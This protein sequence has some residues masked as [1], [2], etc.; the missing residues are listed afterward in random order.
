[1]GT[2]VLRGGNR[3]LTSCCLLSPRSNTGHTLSQTHTVASPLSPAWAGAPSLGCSCLLEHRGLQGARLCLSRWIMEFI[4]SV[5][6]KL[7]IENT[8]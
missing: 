8:K 1:M 2:M 6:F 3:H 7:H 5:S 4:P